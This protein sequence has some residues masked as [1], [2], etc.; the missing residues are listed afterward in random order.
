MVE[1][2]AMGTAMGTPRFAYVTPLLHKLHWLPGVC[3]FFQLQFKV[4]VIPFKALYNP[5]PDYVQVFLSP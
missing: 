2:A 3:V 5:E 1:N 4:L